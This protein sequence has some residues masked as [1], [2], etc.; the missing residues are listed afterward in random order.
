MSTVHSVQWHF[1]KWAAWRE[2]ASMPTVWK[3]NSKL[4][5]WMPQFEPAVR[6]VLSAACTL[7]LVPPGDHDLLDNT[8][9][10]WKQTSLVAR[11]TVLALWVE[12]CRAIAEGSDPVARRVPLELARTQR[13]QGS[14]GP[15]ARI[16][17]PTTSSARVLR[18]ARSGR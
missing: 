2:S 8:I 12:V 3:M 16:A 13:E 1:E 5:V 6:P 15:G 17:R 4:L 9:A 11:A 18:S 7:G 14:M 10:N